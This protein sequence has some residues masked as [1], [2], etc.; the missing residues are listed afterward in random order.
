MIFGTYPFS[1]EIGVKPAGVG[2]VLVDVD[3]VS[4]VVVATF[5]MIV[6][7]EAVAVR[8]PKVM[9]EYSMSLLG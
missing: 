5:V 6:V 8:V 7:V 2:T 9:S 1:S 3:V 4:I